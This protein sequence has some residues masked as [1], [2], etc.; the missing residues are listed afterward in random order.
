MNVT[1]GSLTIQE[2]CML[3]RKLVAVAVLVVAPFAVR[4]AEPENPYKKAEKGQW[5]EY[6][7]SGKFGGQDV[8]GSIK[9]TVVEK[10]DKSVTLEVKLSFAGF[11]PPAQ[12]QKIDLTKPFDPATAANFPG[13]G[14]IKPKFDK[15]ESGKE[16]VEVAGKKYEAEWTSYKVKISAMG[17]E[18]EGTLK[19]WLSK[20]APVGGLVKTES[21]MSFMGNDINSS[22]ELEKSGKD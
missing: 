1:I 9:K 3:F 13:G 22:T 15:Q 5:A 6:K 16:T 21:K 4:A 2:C 20:D 17:N 7:M 14:Q 10:D 8:T 18:I 19:L 11:D 12:K